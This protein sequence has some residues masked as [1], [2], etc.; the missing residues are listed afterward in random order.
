MRG[1]AAELIT[2]VYAERQYKGGANKNEMKGDK[3]V[4]KYCLGMSTLS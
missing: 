1:K 3:L 4:G 2:C